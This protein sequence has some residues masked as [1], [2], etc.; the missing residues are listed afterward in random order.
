MFTSC[1]ERIFPIKVSKKLCK[2]C[3]MKEELEKKNNTWSHQFSG[4]LD[5]VKNSLQDISAISQ[6]KA[7]ISS[8]DIFTSNSTQPVSQEKK[9]RYQK[10]EE[11]EIRRNS[12]SLQNIKEMQ[13]SYNIMS[14][15]SFKSS[16]S[17]FCDQ[18]VVST[19]RDLNISTDIP[20]KAEQSSTIPSIPELNETALKLNFQVSELK[21]YKIAG[22]YGE[23]LDRIIASSNNNKRVSIPAVGRARPLKPILKRTGSLSTDTMK[24]VTIELMSYVDTTRTTSELKPSFEGRRRQRIK[25]LQSHQHFR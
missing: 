8:T 19:A 21:S 10:D 25:S 16:C 23:K 22:H 2:L 3:I 7:T 14:H 4:C 15:S 13:K 24:R 1:C 9:D 18:Q 12:G 11:P 17:S 20:V 5:E 6:T